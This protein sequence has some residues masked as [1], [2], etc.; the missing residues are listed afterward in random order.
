MDLFRNN[1]IPFKSVAWRTQTMM[2]T[3]FPLLWS[4]EAHCEAD[5]MTCFGAKHSKFGED[6]CVVLI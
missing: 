5:F 1:K 2:F 3:Q 6:G 4:S